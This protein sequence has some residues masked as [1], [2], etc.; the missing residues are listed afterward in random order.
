MVIG[1]T[2]YI[3]P[4]C[5]WSNVTYRTGVSLVQRVIQDRS[6][7]GPTGHTDPARHW[8]N[9]LYRPGALLVQ[10]VTQARRVIGTLYLHINSSAFVISTSTKPQFYRN[11]ASIK[12]Q[13]LISSQNLTQDLTSTKLISRQNLI[14]NLTSTRFWSPVKTWPRT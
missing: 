12:R 4:A 2:G 7:I 9:V 8:S 3:G 14:Q 10:G 13:P 6:V 5:H 11:L 1:P